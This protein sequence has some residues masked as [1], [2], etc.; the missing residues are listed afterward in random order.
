M[1][2]HYGI[3]ADTGKLSKRYKAKNKPKMPVEKFHVNAFDH[4]SMPILNS[5]MEWL[6]A[7]WGLI[8]SF[9]T[10]IEQQLSIRTKTLNAR[11]DS[12]LEKASF[13]DS[14]L[15]H[16]CLI[17]ATHFFEWQTKGK[18]KYP[19]MLRVP[20]VEIFSFAGIFSTYTNANTG[21]ISNSF[22]IITDDA[23]GFL[24]EIHNTAHRKPIVL[25]P[26]FENKWL[27]GVFD[28]EMLTNFQIPEKV[29]DAIPMPKNSKDWGR[30]PQNNQMSLFD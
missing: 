1:C 7:E 2:Y 17:P 20:D 21:I 5:N 9:A 4:E 26:E 28:T 27:E 24:G 14:I 18:G 25:K 15:H 10:S 13:K 19:F 3:K 23:R 8:P 16:R 22:S 6:E 12:L 30:D 11:F 29:W